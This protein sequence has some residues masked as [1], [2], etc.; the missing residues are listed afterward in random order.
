[1][2]L[3]G[4]LPF[5]VKL[6]EAQRTLLRDT[7]RERRFARGSVVQNTSENCLGLLLVTGGQL[8]VYTVQKRTGVNAVSAF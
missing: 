4:F 3:E 5:W 8:R 7:V 6:T 1:M 2:N